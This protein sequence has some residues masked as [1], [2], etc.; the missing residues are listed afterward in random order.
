MAKCDINVILFVL[1]FCFQP[2]PSSSQSWCQLQRAEATARLWVNFPSPEG[3]RKDQVALSL[4]WQLCDFD[5]TSPRQGQTIC[6]P[7]QAL[8]DP[9]FT[10]ACQEFSTPRRWGSRCQG[11][12]NQVLNG[13]KGTAKWWGKSSESFFP[14]WIFITAATPTSPWKKEMRQ[15]KGSCLRK[16]FP[17]LCISDGLL[18]RSSISLL[19]KRH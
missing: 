2:Q 19:T 5:S 11:N 9:A 16:T 3:R 1:K 6:M 7:N 10:P 15:M 17:S 18:V 13:L 14:L 12:Q 4:G 8:G